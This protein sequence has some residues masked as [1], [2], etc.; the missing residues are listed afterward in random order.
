VAHSQH[1][2]DDVLKL[3]PPVIEAVD[4]H[5]RRSPLGPPIFARVWNA[6][7]RAAIWFLFD[8]DYARQYIKRLHE[9]R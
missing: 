3:F 6:R 9:E 2:V 8:L 4:E 5:W 1:Q 7:V